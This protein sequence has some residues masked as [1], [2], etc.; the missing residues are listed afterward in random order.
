[1][2]TAEAA[3]RCARARR[4][5]WSRRDVLRMGTLAGGGCAIVALS[6]FFAAGEPDVQ[7]QLV[8]VTLSVLGAAVVTAGAFAW[9]RSGRRMVARR[10][11]RLLGA[12]PIDARTAAPAADL[13][14][15]PTAKWFHRADCLLVDG[16]GWPAFP[17]HTHE[18]AGRRPCPAC[19][20]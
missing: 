20:P 5:M 8:F 10:I 16:R 11:Q 7:S 19:A 3:T 9:V 12:A 18:A 15:G 4:P 17:R 6:W 2:T 13:V 1:M 14:A